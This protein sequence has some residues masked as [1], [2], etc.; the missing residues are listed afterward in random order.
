MNTQ[1]KRYP[2]VKFT[3][4]IALLLTVS[5]ILLAVG[6]Q[7]D[8]LGNERIQT[9]ATAPVATTI[10]DSQKPKY[11]FYDQLKKR[12]TEVNQNTSLVPQQEVAANDSGTND[13]SDSRNYV[14]QVG[15]YANSRDANKVKKKLESLGYPARVEKPNSK[16]LVQAGPFTGIKKARAIEKR[17]NNQQ[18]ETL[19]KRLK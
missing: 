7:L 16:Y 1:K 18:M 9:V 14:V 19:V 17:L 8:F 5:G 10:P 3:G 2:L 4:S 15:A 11:S 12:T 6:G 13:D